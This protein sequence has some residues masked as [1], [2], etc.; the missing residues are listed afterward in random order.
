MAHGF[1][2]LSMATAFVPLPIAQRTLYATPHEHLRIK[3][4]RSCDA[5]TPDAAASPNARRSPSQTPSAA[6]TSTSSGLRLAS[7]TGWV[8]VSFIGYIQGSQLLNFVFNT[9]LNIGRSDSADAFGPFVTLL[10]L[11]YSVVLGQVYQYYFDRQGQIQDALFQETASLRTLYETSVVLSDRSD[12]E[13]TPAD[14][15]EMLAILHKVS[16]TTLATAFNEQLSDDADASDQ[17]TLSLL[18]MLGTLEAGAQA[19]APTSVRLAGDAMDRLLAARAQRRSAVAAELPPVQTLTQ[20][21]VA[22]VLQCVRVNRIPALSI[23]PARPWRSGLGN[24][25]SSCGTGLASCWSTW[26]RPFWRAFCLRPYLRASS[27]SVPSLTISPIRSAEAGA[28]GPRGKS[29]TRWPSPSTARS[30]ERA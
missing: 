18:Q 5:A 10:G 30:C 23:R 28:W 19:V 8:V 21:V 12:T 2:I 3:A 7:L 6:A 22:A 27:S 29:S 4:I 24:D 16:G 20:R 17:Q 26:A 11:V 1:V 13:L 15:R 25:T 14:R 9:Y